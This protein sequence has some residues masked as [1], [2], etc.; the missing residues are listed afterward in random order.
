MNFIVIYFLL[1]TYI[2]FYNWGNVKQSKEFQA[3]KR[4]FINE[5]ISFC[6]IRFHIKY[7]PFLILIF[8][9]LIWLRLFSLLKWKNL[10]LIVELCFHVYLIS[11]TLQTIL[12]ERHLFFFGLTKISYCFK[13]SYQLI[14]FLSTFLLNLLEI[15]K[16]FI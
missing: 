7:L 15:F 3:K 14:R 13:I 8:K 11:L 5:E 6:N 10:H 12:D 2:R 9:N 16:P 1:I 4:N